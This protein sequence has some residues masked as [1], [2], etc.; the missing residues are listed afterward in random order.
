MGKYHV[1]GTPKSHFVPITNYDDKKHADVADV[2]SRVGVTCP[3]VRYCGGT[4]VFIH[5]AVHNTCVD[6]ARQHDK[7]N[8]IPLQ[9]FTLQ[10]ENKTIFHGDYFSATWRMKFT[11]SGSKN[12]NFTRYRHICLRAPGKCSCNAIG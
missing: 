6:D 3:Y 12:L 11:N 2:I 9:V 1:T 4:C 10:S 5:Y 7:G 8:M